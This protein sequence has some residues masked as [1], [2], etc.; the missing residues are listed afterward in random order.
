ME[1]CTSSLLSFW[2]HILPKTES[3]PFLTGKHCELTVTFPKI[4]GKNFLQTTCL[5]IT[6][7]SCLSFA[8][9]VSDGDGIFD[10]TKIPSHYNT[11]NINSFNS[12]CDG[13]NMKQEKNTY[14]VKRQKR[15]YYA[16]QIDRQPHAPYTTAPPQS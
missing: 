10:L 1:V 7:F 8:S 12:K 4:L 9:L 2:A 6:I 3:V 16:P 14:I 15:F 13:V 5:L 11:I